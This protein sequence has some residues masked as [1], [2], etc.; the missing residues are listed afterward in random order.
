MAYGSRAEDKMWLHTLRALST[1]LGSK[2]EPTFERVKVDKKRAW[3]NFKNIRRN[4]M[5]TG[6]F[7]RKSKGDV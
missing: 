5:L 4:A 1:H 2:Y 3:K 6:M 7:R